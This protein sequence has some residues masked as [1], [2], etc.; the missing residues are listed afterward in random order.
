LGDI[1]LYSDIL[2][3]V[4]DGQ[5]NTVLP[6]FAVEVIAYANGA[7]TLNWVAPTENTDG[8]PLLDLAGY[9]IHWGS[10][11]GDYSSS[12]EI[13][14]PGITTYMVEN[15]TAGTHYF[16]VRAINT[17]GMASTLSNEAVKTIAP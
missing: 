17:Q 2:I 1:G 6:V 5:A 7:A 8:S 3:T 9:E 16:A 12:V 11:S 15:L 10:Q 13:S 4:S 14:N